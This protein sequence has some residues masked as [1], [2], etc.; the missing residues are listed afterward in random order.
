MRQAPLKM[1]TH[2]VEEVGGH[3]C[4]SEAPHGAVCWLCLLDSDLQRQHN[5][6]ISLLSLGQNV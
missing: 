6:S 4:P 3:D 2:L 5:I 1:L